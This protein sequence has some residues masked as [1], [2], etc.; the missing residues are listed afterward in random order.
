MIFV[1][2]N[3]IIDLVEPNGAWREWS[4]EVL[5]SQEAPLITSAVTLAEAARQFHSLKAELSFLAL[6]QIELLDMPPEAAFR[7]GKAH[8]AYRAA[9]GT[10]EAVLADF[11]IGGHATTLG[12]TLLTRDRGRFATYFPE[13]QLITPE[14][15]A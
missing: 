10:R 3:I 11:L 5:L 14:N 1:D 2:S 6:M 13:L 15:Q 8:A 4:E 12:A 7:A 9:G